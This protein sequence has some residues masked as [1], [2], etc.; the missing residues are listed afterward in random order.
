MVSV[1]VRS[2]NHRQSASKYPG[3]HSLS[4]KHISNSFLSR[5][6]FCVPSFRSSKAHHLAPKIVTTTKR[7]VK[8]IA[9]IDK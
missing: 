6:I 3:I 4:F 1:K 9:V 8:T 7:M 2:D 5:L